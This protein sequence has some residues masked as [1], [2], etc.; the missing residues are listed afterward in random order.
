MNP[1]HARPVYRIPLADWQAGG[2]SFDYRGQRIFYQQSGPLDAPVLLLIHGFPTAS[3]DWEALWTPLTR[4]YRVFALDMIGFGFSAKPHDYPYSIMDQA[5]LHEALLARYNI[6]TYHILAH[7]YGDT[8]A[9]ELL[10]RQNDSERHPNYHAPLRP[11]LLSV[12]FLNGGLFPETHRPLMIQRLLRSPLGPLLTRFNTRDRLMQNMQ[13][14][15]GHKTQPDDELIDTFWALIQHHA[16]NLILPQL[17]HYIGDRKAHR[18]RWVGALKHASIPLGLINGASDPV[19]GGHMVKRYRQLIK[20]PTYIASF[21][22][23]GHYPQLE[24][25]RDVLAAYFKFRRS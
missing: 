20:T 7:D 18:R 3:W 14:V 2:E 13:R 25:P 17:L 15:F 12:C 10:A 23:I 4:R 5:D 21:D 11:Q 1:V 24:A 6:H 8:V 9:Q 16:G 22:A 19:S